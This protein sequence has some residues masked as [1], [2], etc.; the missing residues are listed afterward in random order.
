MSKFIDRECQYYSWGDVAPREYGAFCRR[1][2]TKT[3]DDVDCA[4]CNAPD[5]YLHKATKTVISC[6]LNNC[7]YN[8][9]YNFCTKDIVFINHKT[10][11]CMDY[12]EMEE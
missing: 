4:T 11:K 5:K 12:V 1:E 10:G 9:E 8:D 6:G 2:K 7:F 3:I